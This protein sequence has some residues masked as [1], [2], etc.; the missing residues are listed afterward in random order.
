MTLSDLR[1]ALLE[2]RINRWLESE[3][4]AAEAR[5][6]VRS[7]GR[8]LERLVPDLQQPAGGDALGTVSLPSSLT[9]LHDL[10]DLDGDGVVD[11]RELVV[12]L[13]ALERPHAGGWNAQRSLMIFRM[14]DLDGDGW[15]RASSEWNICRV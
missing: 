10:F 3:P 9:A 6:D 5:L 15:L 11:A 8:L 14:H 13:L 2:H 7:F 1:S 12:G 4:R